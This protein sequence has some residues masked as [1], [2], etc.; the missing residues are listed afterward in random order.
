MRSDS[1][2]TK[3]KNLIIE[4]IK[5]SKKEF[6]VKDLYNSLEKKVGLTT[7]YRYI[8][9]LEHDGVLSKSIH[10]DN[11]TYYQ[12]LE[13]CDKEDHFYLKCEKCGNM[14]HIDCECILDLS[15][16]ILKKHKFKTNKDHII[17]NGICNN[18]NGYE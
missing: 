4:I 7:I 8:D 10:S 14:E 5:K 2:N 15:N 9:K 6:T 11:V 3:Q 1:Y 17:I 12:Y 18:C 16:H 13:H